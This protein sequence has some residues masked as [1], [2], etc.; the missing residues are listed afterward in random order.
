METAFKAM[1]VVGAMAETGNPN[2][3]SDAGVGALALR[4]SIRGAFLNVKINASGL[5]DKEFVE[6]ILEKAG[7]LEEM[8]NREEQ[9]ILEMVNSRM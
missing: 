2:S 1:E 9:R 3:V 8:A 4:S 5:E 7:H 6:K